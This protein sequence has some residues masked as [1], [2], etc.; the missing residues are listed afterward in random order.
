MKRF[1]L[2]FAF[3]AIIFTS[4]SAQTT[5]TKVT[6]MSELSLGQNVI[7]VGTDGE[8]NNFA[9]GN[10]KNASG[11]L[12]NRY[13][14]AVTDNSGEITLTACTSAEDVAS[15]CQ[16]SISGSEGAWEFYDAV[17]A[18]FLSPRIDNDTKNGLVVSSSTMT[19][20]VTM[21]STTGLSTILA[22]TTATSRKQMRFNYLSA[23]FASYLETYTTDVSDIYIYASS[24]INTSPLITISSPADASVIQQNNVIVNFTIQN[25]VVG[26]DGNL[27][28]TLNSETPVT[29]SDPATTSINFTDL[30]DG[31]YS[32]VMTLDDGAKSAVYSTTLTF[33]IFTQTSTPKNYTLV[34]NIASIQYGKKCM[35]VGKTASNTYY[36]LG[37]QNS[38]SR[39]AIDVTSSI[40]GDILTVAPA[41]LSSESTTP[42]E[43]TI[44]GATDAWVLHDGLNETL[45]Y[46]SPKAEDANGMPGSANPVTW[47]ISIDG[48]GLATI[49]ATD[50]TTYPRPDMR[51]N[52]NTQYGTPLFSCYLTSQ[53][54]AEITHVYIYMSDEEPTTEPDLTITSPANNATLYTSTVNVTYSVANFVLGTEGKVKY[55]LDTEDPIYTTTQIGSISLAEGAHSITMELV[56]MSNAPLATPIV[57]TVNFT[58]S[59]EG[60]Q[61]TPIHDI[62]Y[63]TAASG[64]SPL[65][66]QSVWVEG[67]V[68]FIQYKEGGTN[69][70]VVEGYYIQDDETPWSGIYVY[71]NTNTVV[72]GNTVKFQATVSEYFSLTELT[73]ISNFSVTS[74]ET[75]VPEPMNVSGVDATTEA[76]EGC[77]VY[78][79]CFTIATSEAYG[80]FNVTDYEGNSFVVNKTHQLH[81]EDQY[82]EVGSSY[83]GYGV[84]NYRD[85]MRIML[86]HVDEV[87]GCFQE[88]VNTNIFNNTAI[89]PNPANDVLFVNTDQVIDNLQI[90]NSLG[91]VV[92]E[93][94]NVENGNSINIQSLNSGLY[95][96]KYSNGNV[97]KIE[98]FV[99]N[100]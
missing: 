10:Q 35:I 83:T 15:A 79:G 33:T 60:P 65:N 22:N 16:F 87:S 73:G 4:V 64:D 99:I 45:P 59:L 62:Q 38:S 32:L 43:I 97:S 51:F 12:T 92:T 2:L 25:F 58:I 68:T 8:G 5:Y 71:D 95:I 81:L 85:M 56:D 21:N 77:Y 74:I 69:D 26:T 7:L 63:T 23:L 70:G 72:L 88:S 11:V 41:I 76:Y 20:N 93:I 47:S 18:G 48:T 52:E 82:L 37:K 9:I 29:I 3:L 86:A 42:Y 98:K 36:A 50:Q 27:V 28:Y 89:Y 80:N 66:G 94:T 1:T 39:A 13:A 46:L 90:I 67:I 96:I 14:I 55:T 91:Q 84:V 57:K 61:T 53:S 40:S 100:N 75:T 44:E 34:T 54:S 19:W 24:E 30:A 78:V 31:D 6:N 17:N 49:V